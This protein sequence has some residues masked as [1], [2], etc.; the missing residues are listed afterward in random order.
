MPSFQ[1]GSVSLSNIL[2]GSHAQKSRLAPGWWGGGAVLPCRSTLAASPLARNLSYQPQETQQSLYL[3]I[4]SKSSLSPQPSS[5]C[6]ITLAPP[7]GPPHLMLSTHHRAPPLIKPQTLLL[8][9]PKA[10]R[11]SPHPVYT[12]GPAYSLKHQQYTNDPEPLLEPNPKILRR[13][14]HLHSMTD[15]KDNKQSKPS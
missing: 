14:T 10:P 9:G 12:Q 11:L 2:G 1:R 4:N 15:H 6:P 8:C 7:G 3:K 5:H 13:P